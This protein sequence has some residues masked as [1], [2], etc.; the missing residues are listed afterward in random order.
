MS[1]EERRNELSDSNGSGLSVSY[2]VKRIGRDYAIERT[3]TLRDGWSTTDWKSKLKPPYEFTVNAKNAKTYS[4]H[5]AAH[6]HCNQL[7]KQN[8]KH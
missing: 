7:A 3:M 6:I 1:K 4:L 2:E 8:S 5:L